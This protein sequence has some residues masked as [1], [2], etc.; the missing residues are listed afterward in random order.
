MWSQLSPRRLQS[1]KNDVKALQLRLQGRTFQQIV[2]ALHYRHRGSAWHAIRRAQ[3]TRL[4]ELARLVQRLG[5]A[6]AER[7]CAAIERRAKAVTRQATPDAAD[8]G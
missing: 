7:R 2:D 5:V 6:D 4:Q 8:R 3:V 1:L